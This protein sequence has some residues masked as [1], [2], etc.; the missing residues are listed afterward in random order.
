MYA[1]LHE[2]IVCGKEYALTPEDDRTNDA[3][4]TAAWIRYALDAQLVAWRQVAG[5][6][7][8]LEATASG[9]LA[10]KMSE[11]ADAGKTPGR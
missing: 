7:C 2:L 10:L 5:N 8:L 6:L 11:R 4:D 9:G 1:L 3:S